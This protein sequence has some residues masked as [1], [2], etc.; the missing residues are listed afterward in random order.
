[1]ADA[2][3]TV[4]I[5]DQRNTPAAY[6]SF[7]TFL[8]AIE[9]L[10]HGIP[11][12]IDRTIWRSQS[13]VVQSQIM[14]ALRFFSLLDDEDRPT[15]AL[16]RLVENK[17]D[18]RRE[19]ISALL[20]HAYRDIIAHDLTK[21]SPKMLEDA[22]DNYHVSGDTKRKAV[23]FFLQAARFADFPMHPLLAGTI[24]TTSGRR[25]KAK[26]RENGEQLPAGS[27]TPNS[28]TAQPKVIELA[29]GGKVSLSIDVDVFSLSPEDRKFVFEI[30]DKLQGYPSNQKN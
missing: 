29:S 9:A 3:K 19:Q 26:P 30:I 15:P 20:H 21:M 27:S 17:Q 11:K 13:G 16:H 10:E 25:R 18:N 23:S 1:M 4:P 8:G 2:A 14:M 28:T 6:V 7:K 12:Q 5:T 24:R 22:M